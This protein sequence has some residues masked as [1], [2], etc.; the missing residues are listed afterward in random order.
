METSVNQRKFYFEKAKDVAL[1]I[2]LLV[3]S[4][5]FYVVFFGADSSENSPDISAHLEA[6]EHMSL[7]EGPGRWLRWAT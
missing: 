2:S 1:L 7:D 3:G 4:L 5:V 6:V